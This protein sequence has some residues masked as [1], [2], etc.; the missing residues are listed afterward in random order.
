MSTSKDLQPCA[1]VSA[2]EYDQA[3]SLLRRKLRDLPLFSVRPWRDCGPWEYAMAHHFMREVLAS[4]KVYVHEVK[5]SVYG[6]RTITV[7]FDND[8]GLFTPR[9]GSYQNTAKIVVTTAIEVLKLSGLVQVVCR[10]HQ[11]VVCE[12]YLTC[13]AGQVIVEFDKLGGGATTLKCTTADPL[14][15]GELAPATSSFEAQYHPGYRN[16]D[17]SIITHKQPTVM[18][19]EYPSMGLRSSVHLKGDTANYMQVTQNIGSGPHLV[20]TLGDGFV[21][22]LTLKSEVADTSNEELDTPQ[23]GRVQSLA[24][25]QLRQVSLR[26]NPRNLVACEVNDFCRDG[27]LTTDLYQ[28]VESNGV[29]G[30]KFYRVL[31]G[32]YCDPPISAWDTSDEELVCNPAVATLECDE[33]G[34]LTEYCQGGITHSFEYLPARERPDGTQEYPVRITSS[35]STADE[36]RLFNACRHVQ[37][38]S[39]N[40]G[41]A[42]IGGILPM[43]VFSAGDQVSLVSTLGLCF[44]HRLLSDAGAMWMISH[45]EDFINSIQWREKATSQ[46]AITQHPERHGFRHLDVTLAIG[47]RTY[48]LLSTWP[49]NTEHMEIPSLP[50]ETVVLRHYSLDSEDT[51]KGETTFS[52]DNGLRFK[53]I[54]VPTWGNL[55]VYIWRSE[56]RSA[57]A[58]TDRLDDNEMVSIHL[59]DATVGGDGSKLSLVF[60]THADSHD[61]FWVDLDVVSGIPC[62]SG[63]AGCKPGESIFGDV[64]V[65]RRASSWEQS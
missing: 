54:V 60:V 45:Q 47:A 37:F 17:V 24:T 5:R 41:I 35:F 48:P 30:P 1:D 63:Y 6:Y 36:V 43:K 21:S 2:E 28:Q 10:H 4:L 13:E 26:E 38:A 11:K 23:L 9:F 3:I 39:R 20:F 55:P 8:I 58:L 33:L 65:H 64:Q 50:Y 44:D 25:Q 14:L 59:L 15:D 62:E 49:P 34:R 57:D 18:P 42:P 51:A 12:V 53:K 19:T 22:R 27:C 61:H 32:R 46:F 7:V 31:R 16:V 56:P 52:Q 40:R 29:C